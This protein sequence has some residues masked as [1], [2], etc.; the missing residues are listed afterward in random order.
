MDDI[1]GSLL[2]G[3][4]TGIVNGGANIIPG[5]VDG[6]L[7][8]N[9]IDQNVNFGPH[10]SACHHTFQECPDGVTW[11]MWLKLEGQQNSKIIDSGGNLPWSMGYCMHRHKTGWVNIVITNTTHVHIL[12]LRHWELGYWVHLVFSLHPITGGVIYLNGCKDPAFSYRT[13]FPRRGTITRYYPFIVGSKVSDRD[14][15][16]MD[17]DNLL[18]WYN[19]LTPEDVLT[20]YL[21][22]GDFRIWEKSSHKESIPCPS[23]Y[24]FFAK[25]IRFCLSLWIDTFGFCCSHTKNPSSTDKVHNIKLSFCKHMQS[26]TCSVTYRGQTVLS[27]VTSL[28]DQ[29]VNSILSNASRDQ[30][31]NN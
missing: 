28:S 15:A 30:P 19:V 27:N 31:S 2:Q 18:I 7:H 16:V 9:G 5:R 12:N 21:Q 23:V 14:Y 13:L 20:L 4:I 22:G 11:A 24:S 8:L 26:S 29:V 25:T 1:Q 10:T 17:I 6:A 3:T